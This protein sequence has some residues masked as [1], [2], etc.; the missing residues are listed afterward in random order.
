MANYTVDR[1]NFD[2]NNYRLK[3]TVSNYVTITQLEEGSVPNTV[4]QENTTANTNYNILLSTGAVN[5]SPVTGKAKKNSYLQY[6]ASGNGK[7]TI[8]NSADN[9]AIVISGNLSSNDNSIEITSLTNRYYTTIGDRYLKMRDSG[10]ENTAPAKTGAVSSISIMSSLGYYIS[11]N[12][13]YSNATQGSFLSKSGLQVKND[14]DGQVTINPG[15]LTASQDFAISVGSGEVLTIPNTR[16]GTFTRF[17]TI[18]NVYTPSGSTVT[19]YGI[20]MN[21][22]RNNKYKTSLGHTEGGGQLR[23]VA[24]DTTTNSDGT[25][26]NTNYIQKMTYLDSNAIFHY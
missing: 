26:T 6:N 15:G 8:G 18:D 22:D 25:P 7:L 4:T 19:T 21:F 14:Q 23:L 11:N 20:G 13:T 3:D 16:L 10:T 2:N 9:K 17:G 1:I 12:N 5:T 24:Y